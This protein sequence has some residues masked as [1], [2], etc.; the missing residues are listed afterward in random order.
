MTVTD[1]LREEHRGLLPH[2][3]QLRAAGE[4]VDRLPPG[5]LREVLDDALSFLR[6]HLVPHALAED[7]ALYPAVEDVMGAPGATATMRRDHVEVVRLV[8]E[9][10]AVR[11]DL[12]ERGPAPAEVHDLQRLLFGLH[13]VVGLHFAKE[14]EVYLP[15][16]D[17][18][19]PA[20]R[21][22]QVFRDM[23]RVA[24][25]AGAAAAA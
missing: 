18:G 9:L 4:A 22:A 1:P 17:A 5:A 24:S 7:A 21:A 12:A 10:A 25:G 3:Q 15:L 14:E 19:L 23:E 20:E 8:D 13:A 16:L 11:A 2:V 6:G